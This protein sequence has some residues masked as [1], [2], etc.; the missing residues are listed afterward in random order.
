GGVGNAGGTGGVVAGA[1]GSIAGTGGST[2]GN[3]CLACVISSCPTAS[4][5]FGN[6]ACVQGIFCGLASCTGTDPAA[7][8]RWLECFDGDAEVALMALQAALCLGQNCGMACQAL[9]P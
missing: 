1:A 9:S 4:D 6:T 8:E 3:D 2:N 5:C 7:L